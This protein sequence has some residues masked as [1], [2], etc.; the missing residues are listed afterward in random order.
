MPWAIRHDALRLVVMRDG[1][2]YLGNEYIALEELPI[3]I[4][5]RLQD[6][7]ENRV[8]LLADARAHY[9]DVKLALARIRLAGVENV[10]FLTDSTPPRA[11]APQYAPVGVAGPSAISKR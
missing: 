2:V 4:R 11:L 5:S 8:Y 9:S 6:G 7:A 10:S 3:E 1:E